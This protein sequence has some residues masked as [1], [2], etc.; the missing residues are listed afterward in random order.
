[1]GKGHEGSGGQRMLPFWPSSVKQCAIKINSVALAISK[2]TWQD[3]K[4]E[5]KVLIWGKLNW[6]QS[7]CALCKHLP[8][9]FCNLE[10]YPRVYKL[11]QG[12]WETKKIEKTVV[13]F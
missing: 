9:Q 8:C 12:G 6:L 1:M 2:S 13:A 5:K 10:N 3:H 11:E 7:F 4:L